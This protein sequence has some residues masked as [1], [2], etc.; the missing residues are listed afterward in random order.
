MCFE[1]GGRWRREVE[2]EYGESSASE[3]VVNYRYYPRRHDVEFCLDY[4]F[5]SEV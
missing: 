4:A 1:L 2:A 3:F 5:R